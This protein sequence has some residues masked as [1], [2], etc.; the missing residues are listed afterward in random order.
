MANDVPAGWLGG[1]DWPSVDN[2]VPNMA[3]DNNTTVAMNTKAAS[4]HAGLNTNLTPKN[5]STKSGNGQ[6]S[7]GLP[8]NTSKKGV[9]TSRA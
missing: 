6:N 3:A 4:E 9:V 5:S 7:T 8:K 1:F 2:G